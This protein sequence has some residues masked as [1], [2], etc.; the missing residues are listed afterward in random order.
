IIGPAGTP[1]APPRPRLHLEGARP[2]DASG[3]WIR[4]R[5]PPCPLSGTW[6]RHAPSAVIRPRGSGRSAGWEASA[7]WFAERAAP[8]SRNA[9]GGCSGRTGVLYH[10]PSNGSP[11]QVTSVIAGR[12]AAGPAIV[13]WGSES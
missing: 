8:R 7:A 3:G 5:G 6:H 12:A 13:A 1:A 2:C 4:G 10:T 11:S 9:R